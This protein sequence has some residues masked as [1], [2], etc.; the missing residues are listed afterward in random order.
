MTKW[1]WNKYITVV[2]MQ[3]H[4]L[5]V[6]VPW[7]SVESKAD[8]ERKGD[9]RVAHLVKAQPCGVQGESQRQGSAASHP[10]CAKSLIFT[11]DATL[12][13]LLPWV[14]EAKQSRTVSTHCLKRNLLTRRLVSSGGHLQIRL[15]QHASYDLGRSSKGREKNNQRS[16]PLLILNDCQELLYENIRFLQMSCFGFR[17]DYPDLPNECT[18]TTQT[19]FFFFLLGYASCWQLA[20]AS[21]EHLSTYPVPADTTM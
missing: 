11:G 9:P 18:R 19:G 21:P 15:C 7:Y 2:L 3:K 6:M 14:R 13:L 16:S 8:Y 10:G 4:S 5:I 1:I 12:A 20:L 17:T